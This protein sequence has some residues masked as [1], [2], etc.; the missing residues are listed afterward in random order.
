MCEIIIPFY[1]GIG[2]RYSYLAATQLERIE[3]ETGC[4]FEWL[5]LASGEL[6]RRANNGASPFN[7]GTASGQYNWAYRQ[8]DAEAWAK[9]YSVP[10]KEP[11]D[12]RV[13]PF[14]LAKACWVASKDEQLVK[15]SQRLFRAVFVDSL[16][17]TREVLGDLASDIGL[18]GQELIDALDAPEIAALH[19]SA[20]DR[21][22]GDGAFGVPSFVVSGQLF[23]GN[24]RLPIVEHLLSGVISKQ[25]N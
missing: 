11:A 19:E 10:Y 21:A 9:F 14:D 22:I 18:S 6:I 13:D 4:Q 17:V 1:F 15:M 23:W 12:F 16:E 3:R 20:L 8:R 2:S 24:D 7:G 5:P 25:R